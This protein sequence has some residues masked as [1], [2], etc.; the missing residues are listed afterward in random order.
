MCHSIKSLSG[1]VGERRRLISLLWTCVTWPAL[2]RIDWWMTDGL[3][4]GWTYEW[5]CWVVSLPGPA[6]PLHRQ[7]LGS[8]WTRI[9]APLQSPY[10]IKVTHFSSDLSKVFDHHLKWRCPACCLQLN[11]PFCVALVNWAS[12]SRC[13][14]RNHHE[15]W[16]WKKKNQKKTKTTNLWSSNLILWRVLCREK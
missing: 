8:L 12:R 5:T 2:P 4:D 11:L 1:C 10:I 6:L 7:A 16:S 13:C 15:H 14:S 9:S 3:M